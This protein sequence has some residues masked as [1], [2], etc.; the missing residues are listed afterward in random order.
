MYRM[1]NII[2]SMYY[3][4]AS[5]PRLPHIPNTIDTKGTA[6]TQVSV[7]NT[8]Q[9][10]STLN[11]QSPHNT[12][13][14]GP[15]DHTQQAIPSRTSAISSGSSRPVARVVYVHARKPTLPLIIYRK[16]AAGSGS[17]VVIEMNFSSPHH[18]APA[19]TFL[20]LIQETT[21]CP[22][23]RGLFFACAFV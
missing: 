6:P 23:S 4:P 18:L 3:T 17:G 7:G 9:S 15:H 20:S 13:R 22:P 21:V 14:T 11:S 2:A 8:S 5:P 1:Q 16:R 12:C 19:C 10:P